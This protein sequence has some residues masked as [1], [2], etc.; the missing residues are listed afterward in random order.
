MTKNQY[1]SE[2]AYDAWTKAGMPKNKSEEFWLAAE[3]EADDY[4]YLV[5]EDDYGGTFSPYILTKVIPV[6]E[7]DTIGESGLTWCVLSPKNNNYPKYRGGLFN[8]D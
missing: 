7:R 8:D 2:K 1:I 5:Y 6:W 4:V 3:K